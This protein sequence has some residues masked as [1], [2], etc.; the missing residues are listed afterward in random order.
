MNI[1]IYSL[2]PDMVRF[3]SPMIDLVNFNV[4]FSCVVCQQYTRI[5]NILPERYR[6][7]VPP[8]P[9]VEAG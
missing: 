9:Q 6:F 1:L 2:L 4:R 7:A 3:N 5:L 8:C